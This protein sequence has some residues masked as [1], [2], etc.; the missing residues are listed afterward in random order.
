MTLHHTRASV[1]TLLHGVG[2]VLGRP[3][4]TFIWALTITWSRLLARVWS[5]PKSVIGFNCV[6]L[7]DPE[8][9]QPILRDREYICI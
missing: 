2:A 5:G 9:I 3:L 1:T 8:T 4:D 7:T 6:D